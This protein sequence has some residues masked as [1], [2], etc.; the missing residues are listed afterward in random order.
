[1]V[2]AVFFFALGE[3]MASPTSQEYIGHIAPENK[4]ALYMGY[5]F[6]A[7]ALGISSATCCRAFCTASWRVTP[8]GPI[9]CGWC[10]R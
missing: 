3:M 1:M 6:L 4:T 9:S 7:I 10:S 8:A 2:L 5:Y